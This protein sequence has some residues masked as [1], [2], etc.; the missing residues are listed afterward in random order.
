MY[1]LGAIAIHRRYHEEDLLPIFE[2][3][4]HCNGTEGKILEC[5]I[6]PSTSSCPLQQSDAGVVCQ[7]IATEKDNC[8]DGQ[9]RLVNGSN[10]LEGRIEMCINKAW[11]SVCDDS[12]SEDDSNVICKELGY[13]ING[14]VPETCQGLLYSSFVSCICRKYSPPWSFLW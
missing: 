4:I 5:S 12:F 11:G 9:V 2:Y 3:D 8:S 14:E 7:A 10:I 6:S 13:R 1:L